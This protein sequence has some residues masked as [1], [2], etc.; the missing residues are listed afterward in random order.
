MNH[1]VFVYGTLRGEAVNPTIYTSLGLAMFN[2]GAFPAAAASRY[3]SIVGQILQVDDE[4]LAALDKYEG[5]E[6]GLYVRER[7]D[8]YQ[9]EPSVGTSP[10]VLFD[11]QE[12]WIYLIGDILIAN[13]DKAVASGFPKHRL[14]IKSGDWEKR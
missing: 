7:V 5:V 4:E 14:R 11:R 12:A 1:N 2:F 9:V 8:C 3:H 10:P 13:M 6:R